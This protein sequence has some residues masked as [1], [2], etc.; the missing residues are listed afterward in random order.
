MNYARI[1]GENLKQTRKSM[2]M[3]QKEFSKLIKMSYQNYSQSERGVYKAGFDKLMEISIIL[4]ITPNELFL[5]KTTNELLVSKKG[6]RKQ[7]KLFSHEFA[8]TDGEYDD[9]DSFTRAVNR[10]VQYKEVE[11]I[12]TVISSKGVLVTIFWT[13]I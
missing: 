3:T 5:D 1:I 6:N 4:G 12:Q 9:F 2:G 10:F 8:L 13:G 11:D 7:V